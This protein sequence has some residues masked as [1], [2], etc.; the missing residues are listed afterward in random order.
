VA[1]AKSLKLKLNN[2]SFHTSGKTLQ[3][4]RERYLRLAIQKA[5]T[6]AGFRPKALA[7]ELIGYAREILGTPEEAQPSEFVGA[8]SGAAKS[9]PPAAQGRDG[10]NSRASKTKVQGR[11]GDKLKFCGTI[12]QMKNLTW[13]ASVRG[14]WVEQPH[15]VWRF[16]CCDG[17][18]FNWSS[19][20]GTL[21]FDGPET[22][23]LRR[24]IEKA[25]HDRVYVDGR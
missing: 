5:A 18:G 14:R 9:R 24:T 3:R 20:T 12:K 13:F 25:L 4:T 17:A 8:V 23:E 6:D 11:G 15:G 22:E 1:K 16:A 19:T 21:W 2:L 7:R 10:R